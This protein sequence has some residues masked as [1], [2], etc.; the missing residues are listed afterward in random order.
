M[1][2]VVTSF[3]AQIKPGGLERALDLTRRGAKSLERTGATSVR[4]FRGA[5]GENYGNLLLAIEYPS[6]KAY[7]VGYDQIMK[8]DEVVSVLA[9]M[10]AADTPYTAQRAI[11]VSTEIPIGTPAKRGPVLQAI[12]SRPNPGRVEDAIELGSKAGNLLVKSGALSSRLFQTGFAGSLS[13]MHVLVTEYANM[14]ALGEAYEKL[15]EAKETEALLKEV[16]GP[17]SPG[18]IISSDIYTELPL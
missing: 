15:M 3:Q 17:K 12:L 8:D 10:D 13:G 18:T 1:P 5:T 9:T 4:A 14:A 16:N 2:A 7:G 11:A 6:M